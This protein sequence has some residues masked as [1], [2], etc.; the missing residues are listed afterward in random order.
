MTVRDGHNAVKLG[1][2]ASSTKLS[3]VKK[4]GRLFIHHDQVDITEIPRQRDR[5]A[6]CSHKLCKVQRYWILDSQCLCSLDPN[7][8]LMENLRNVRVALW[9][10]VEANSGKCVY[11]KT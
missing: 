11:G 6:E 1:F 7:T 10:D 4:K 2:N 8:D 3:I 5:A 9:P